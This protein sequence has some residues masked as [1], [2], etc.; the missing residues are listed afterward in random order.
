MVSSALA[1]SSLAQGPEPPSSEAS[2][3]PPHST[4]TLNPLPTYTYR[5]FPMAH[6]I[7]KSRL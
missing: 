7:G 3:N 4:L 5:R 1:L 2:D 6:A